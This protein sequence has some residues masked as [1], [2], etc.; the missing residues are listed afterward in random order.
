M[1]CLMTAGAR[2]R[3]SRAMASAVLDTSALLAIV[4]AET[5]ADRVVTI[6]DDAII[7]AVNVAEVLGQARSARLLARGSEGNPRSF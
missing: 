3:V 4:N 5:G 1:S 7:S 2:W 6:I